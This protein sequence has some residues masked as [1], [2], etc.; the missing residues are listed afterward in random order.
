MISKI[1][2]LL[3]AVVF[4]VV[5][6]L[7]KW[8]VSEHIVRRAL[9]DGFGEV[10]S[11]TEWIMAA[12]ERLPYV[13]IEILPFFNIVMVWNHG[14]SFGMFN[15]E[16]DYGQ[17]VLIVLSAV[18]VLWFVGWLFYTDNKMYQFGSSLVIGGAIG[19]VF[20][21]IR[22]GA[23][24]DFLDFHIWGY[25]WPAFNFADSAIVIGVILLILCGMFFEKSFS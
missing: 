13:G 25:H 16:T 11:L 15:H 3:L 8:A 7:S 14:I 21:R 6:Q 23:V 2:F 5:D 18:I 4:V 19:N 22:F 20:D 1:F 17:I 12:P 10:L 24:M 9:G